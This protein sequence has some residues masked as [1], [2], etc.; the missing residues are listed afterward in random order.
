[1][2]YDDNDSL[3]VTVLWFILTGALNKNNE[4]TTSSL[5][6]FRST[7]SGLPENQNE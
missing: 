5:D 2:I 7:D 6:K 4:V 3:V 1:M